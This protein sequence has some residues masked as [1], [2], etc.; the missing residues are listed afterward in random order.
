MIIKI[1]N[2]LGINEWSLKGEPSNENEFNQMFSKVV[3]IDEYGTSIMSQNP[4]DFGITWNVIQAKIDEEPMRL[5]R[6]ERDQRIAL[7]DWR[8]RSDLTPRQEWYEY[9]QALRDLPS[10]AEPMLDENGNLTNVTWPEEP[11]V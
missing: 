7:T 9:C 11:T 4:D 2:E 3:G 8:F 5:L 1:L 6:L 10:T